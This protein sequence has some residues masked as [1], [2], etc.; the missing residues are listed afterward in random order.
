MLTETQ[1][2]FFTQLCAPWPDGEVRVRSQAGR[3][4]H[5]IT[6]RMLMN[7][8]DDVAG[9]TGWYPEYKINQHGLTC[10]LHIRVP[11]DEGEWVWIAKEDGGGFAGM[12]SGEDD[13]K[14]GYSDALKRAG[15]AWG[16]ARYLYRE[17]TPAYLGDQPPPPEPA[18]HAAHGAA[19]GPHTR[20]PVGTGAPAPAPNRPGPRPA[21]PAPY[22]RERDRAPAPNQSRG[23]YDNFRPPSRPGPAAFAWLKGLE[24]HFGG[25]IVKMANDVASNYGLPTYAKEWDADDLELIAWSVIDQIRTWDNYAGEFEHL[26]DPRP[27]N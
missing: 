21:A 20:Q 15:V 22:G 18:H 12:Q 4:F 2:D 25:G 23:G 10:R 7:R 11:G 17:G 26:E 1:Q 6:A 24:T 27:K 16:I 9:P 13:Q 19:R 14:S 3:T 8:L 5:Y